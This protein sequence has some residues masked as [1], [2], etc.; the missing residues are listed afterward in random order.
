MFL[1]ANLMWLFSI[2]TA[3]LNCVFA[4]LISFFFFFSSFFVSDIFSALLSYPI[5]F[6]LIPSG[7]CLTSLSYSITQDSFLSGNIFLPKTAIPLCYS[8]FNYTIIFFCRFVCLQLSY[9]PDRPC[10][11]SSFALCIYSSSYD[12]CASSNIS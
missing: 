11:Y 3:F 1:L 7:S 6:S 5:D 12:S 9:Y 4:Y 2:F 10:D 8:F